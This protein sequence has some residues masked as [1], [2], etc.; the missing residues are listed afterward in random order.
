MTDQE[1]AELLRQAKTIAVVG[2]SSSPT[3]P[4][5][6]V[7]RYLQSQGYHIVPINPM[8]NEVLGQ[9]AYPDLRSVPFDVDMLDV[10]RRSE[11][12]G[13]HVDEAI[14]RG[15]EIV[16]LQLGVHD[17]AAETRAREHGISVVTDRCIAVEH[18]RLIGSWDKS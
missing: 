3:R 9:Q 10:F 11:F 16:W 2:L 4:S 18:R 5:Y 1:I 8:L 7:A 14:D 6:T 13:P 15:V 17:P 12:V